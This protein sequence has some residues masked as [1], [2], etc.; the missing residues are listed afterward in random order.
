MRLRLVSWCV[1]LALVVTPAAAFW[2]QFACASTTRGASD[3]HASASAA[4][5][6]APAAHECRNLVVTP[7][8]PQAGVLLVSVAAGRVIAASAVP[9]SSHA[10]AT[11]AL[12]PDK[13]HPLILRI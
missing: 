5:Q 11:L 4:G 3:C 6:F 12:L 7:A 9:A 2:C 13:P 10:G 1:L 8:V